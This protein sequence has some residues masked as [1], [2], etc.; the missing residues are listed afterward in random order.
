MMAHKRHKKEHKKWTYFLCVLCLF[1]A[2]KYATALAS[3]E[4]YRGAR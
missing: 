1:V 2:K 3:F 4:S